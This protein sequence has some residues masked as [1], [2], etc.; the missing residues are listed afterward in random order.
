MNNPQG[1]QLGLRVLQPLQNGSESKKG[2]YN[3]YKL[4]L[5][6]GKQER[7][8]EES[9]S[10]INV[11]WLDSKHISSNS[12]FCV[13]SVIHS[14]VLDLQCFSVQSVPV[15][16]FISQIAYRTLAMY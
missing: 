5:R 15:Q 7:K 13:S 1:W 16:T 8:D 10:F 3:F 12:V 4:C 9:D 2:K 14:A 11:R 6:E